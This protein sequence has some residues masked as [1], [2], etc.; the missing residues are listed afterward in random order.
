M[1]QILLKYHMGVIVHFQ[2]ELESE[3]ES[4]SLILRSRRST[5]AARH[6]GAFSFRRTNSR[7]SYSFQGIPPCVDETLHEGMAP[8]NYMKRRRPSHGNQ[9]LFQRLTLR[10]SCADSVAA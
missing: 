6:S 10:S 7:L 1:P 2:S 8:K 4:D 5:S 3:S 9:P